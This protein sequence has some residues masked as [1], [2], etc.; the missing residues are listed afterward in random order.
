VSF[1]HDFSLRF[2]STGAVVG[3]NKSW[4]LSVQTKTAPVPIRSEKN[5]YSSLGVWYSSS[6][7]AVTKADVLPKTGSASSYETTYFCFLKSDN[8]IIIC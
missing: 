4:F 8:A 5:G 2:L 3:T 7:E 6:I 1:L